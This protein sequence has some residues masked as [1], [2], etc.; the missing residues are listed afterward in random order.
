[1]SDVTRAEIIGVPPNGN[2]Q[3]EIV[4]ES[5]ETLTVN[6]PRTANHLKVSFR[7]DERYIYTDAGQATA[8]SLDGR[9]QAIPS[10]TITTLLK[11]E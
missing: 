5:G 2:L 9:P 4:T 7:P 8:I 6:L 10:G 11:P 3:I 1:M